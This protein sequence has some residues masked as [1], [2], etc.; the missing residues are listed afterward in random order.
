[1]LNISHCNLF[2]NKCMQVTGLFFSSEIA[3]N[4][5]WNSMFRLN[6]ISGLINSQIKSIGLGLFL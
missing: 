3:K 1:M 2:E 5:I 4:T 6:S